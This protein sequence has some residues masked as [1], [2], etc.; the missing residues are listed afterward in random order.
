MWSYANR[1]SVGICKT[2]KNC[3]IHTKIVVFWIQ[4]KMWSYV[5]L[6]ESLVFFT[7]TKVWLPVF[8]FWLNFRELSVTSQ[9]V[10]PT[11]GRYLETTLYDCPVGVCAIV[12]CRCGGMSSPG[13]RLETMTP[14]HISPE[15]KKSWWSQ[16]VIYILPWQRH[17]KRVL[18]PPR[19]RCVIA[20][21]RG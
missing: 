12:H 14:H 19:E 11:D 17:N 1:K 8:P 10:K 21:C 2:E 4:T 7:Y 9:K 18:R 6:K 5:T 20:W 15:W 3:H 13:R 16:Q